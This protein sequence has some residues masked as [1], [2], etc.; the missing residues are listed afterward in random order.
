MTIPVPKSRDQKV[1]VIPKVVVMN[2]N[3]VFNSF[4]LVFLF[5]NIACKMSR[6]SKASRSQSVR[7]LTSCLDLKLKF[8]I[9]RYKT[10]HLKFHDI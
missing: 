1:H 4:L 6:Y 10:F 7:S 8:I 2:E 9:S 5:E 3:E